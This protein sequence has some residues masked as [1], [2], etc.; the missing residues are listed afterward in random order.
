[1]TRSVARRR[2]DAGAFLAEMS[3][4][5][6]A[7]L[8]DYQHVVM[9]NM[10]RMADSG[11]RPVKPVAS[12]DNPVKMVGSTAVIQIAGVIFPRPNIYTRWYGG[13]ALSEIVTA[14]STAVGTPQIKRIVLQINSP[15]GVVFGVEE[16]AKLIADASKKKPI[17]AQSDQMVASA[18]YWLA[19]QC[20][21]IE[22]TPGALFGSIGV[23]TT[24]MDYSKYFSEVGISVT[25]ITHGELKDYTSPYKPLSEKGRAAIQDQTTA[26]G[27]AFD[28]A[29]AKGRKV[30]LQTVQSQFGQGRTFK[31]DQAKERGLIDAVVD[32]LSID[33]DAGDNGDTELSHNE[34]PEVVSAA[35]TVAVTRETVPSE[36]TPPEAV[37][38]QTKVTSAPAAKGFSKMEKLIMALVVYGFATEKPDEKTATALIT[39]IYAARGQ[40]VPEGEGRE[41]Q[42]TKD[43]HAWSPNGTGQATS[44]PEKA[45]ASTEPAKEGNSPGKEASLSK[46]DFGA[47][48]NSL[49]AIAAQLNAGEPESAVSD[50]ELFEAIADTDQPVEA[51]QK[52]WSKAMND[53]PDRQAPRTRIAVSDEAR[54]TFTKD[55][56][57]AICDRV[58]IGS[59]GRQTAAHS[60][61]YNDIIR[62]FASNS[63]DPEVRKA[64]GRD[65]KAVVK[66]L[67]AEKRSIDFTAG[68]TDYLRPGDFPALLAG[69]ISKSIDEGMGYTQT[70]YQYWSGREVDLDAFTPHL[71]VADGFIDE[72][73]K[74]Q[75]GKPAPDVKF[76]DET[77]GYIEVGKHK[78]RLPLT[79]D[80]AESEMLLARFLRQYSMLGD[81]YQ[82]TI[83]LAHI[84][85]LVGNKAL[86]ADNV[87]FFHEDHANVV[88]SGNG[89]P[90][91]AAQAKLMR[92]LHRKQKPLGSDHSAG[93]APVTALVPTDLEDAMIQTYAPFGALPEMK[94]PETDGNI[95]V[96]RGTMQ[97][98]LVD[99]MLD[100]YSTSKWYT[101]GNLRQVRPFVH[102]FQRGYGPGGKRRTYFDEA[103]ETRYFEFQ[104][105]FGITPLNFRGAAENFGA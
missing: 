68:G 66:A 15:G 49:R 50:D 1:M 78:G 84:I 20:S 105:S 99:S 80:M 90:P 98:L 71:I 87:A 7:I 74:S 6:W 10:M 5:S 47:R 52:R 86:L 25:H 28:G 62:Q 102:A 83:N 82:R 104:G 11:D 95:N 103:S 81:A 94:N 43:L 79:A 85:Y 12:V 97:N 45:T 27:M 21:R 56:A 37:A 33:A 53:S 3:H 69:M 13:C 46:V 23:I 18:A 51:I 9:A 29:V 40:K 36:A 100:A 59:S 93:L 60:M 55:A 88:T 67:M 77:R 91:S 101:F 73:E 41:D 19:S 30:S 48:A 70:S 17:I 34:S 58:G 63:S 72:L 64:F 44:Q 4:Q 2:K 8:E 14:I 22:G 38:S 24:H 96:H 32:S 76:S 31:A 54:A 39:G 16:A 89:G 92:Q 61:G 26:Y 35:S 42:I 65:D 75:D 57:D